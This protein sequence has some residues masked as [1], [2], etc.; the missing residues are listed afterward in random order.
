M[1]AFL[2][3]LQAILHIV[4]RFSPPH[5]SRTAFVASWLTL[6]LP[7]LLPQILHAQQIE[8]LKSGVVKIT[9]QVEGQQPRVGTGFIVRLDKDAAYIV[10]ASHVIEGDSKPQVSFFPQ[11]QQSFPARIIGIESQNQKGL[12]VVQV[13]G[14]IPDGLIALA[15]DHTNEIAGGEPVTFIG[16]PRTL[17]PWAVS[18]GS[19]NGLKGPELSFQALIEEGHSGSP[20]LHRGAVV[21]VVTDARDRMGYAVPSAILE[22]ALKGWQVMPEGTATREITSKDGAR[23]VL[24]RA[25]RIPT[26]IVAAYGGGE[27]E[28]VDAPPLSVYVADDFYIDK[29][30]VTVKRFKEFLE[31]T[32]RRVTG[33]YGEARDWSGDHNQAVDDVGW[34]DAVAFCKWAGKRLPTEDEWEKAA[35]DTEG[36]ILDPNVTE[37][38]SSPY[39]ESRFSSSS[40]GDQR[41]KT[42]RG[43]V[44]AFRAKPIEGS[45]IDYQIRKYARAGEGFE[46]FRCAQDAK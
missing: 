15:L 6:L 25:G 38:T 23:M 13:S 10:T 41:E 26:K 37:W 11:P 4:P 35:H 18:T 30:L 29:S 2:N 40:P 32:G 34:Y 16:F 20:V 31:T 45:K 46:G 1:T 22:V 24:I 7:S 44:S 3:I 33:A 28:E 39:Q 19:L 27:V 9:A 43:S 8:E 5:G 14:A 12:A 36:R 21:G 17:A 42:I